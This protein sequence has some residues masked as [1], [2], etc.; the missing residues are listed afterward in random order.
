MHKMTKEQ[1]VAILKDVINNF[2]LISSPT[3][4][5]A[6]YI[7]RSGK[8]LNTK[9]PYSNAQHENIADYIMKNYGRNDL[10]QNNGS[11]FITIN[12]GAIRVTP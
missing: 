2:G 12:C 11:R 7:L 10:D 1:S 4:S 5:D 8:I 6:S 9:G 3:K